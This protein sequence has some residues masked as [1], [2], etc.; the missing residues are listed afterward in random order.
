ML[1]ISNPVKII[2]L[3]LIDTTTRIVVVGRF[4][5]GT[6]E[7]LSFDKATHKITRA[8]S[9]SDD[10]GFETDDGGRLIIE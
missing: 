10:F 8:G 7:L 6:N 4:P 1:T 2:Q 5:E 9:I 3:E